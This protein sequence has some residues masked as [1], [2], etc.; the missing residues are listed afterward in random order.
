MNPIKV[1]IKMSLLMF[2]FFLIACTGSVKDPFISLGDSTNGSLLTSP[3][4]SPTPTG[5][6]GQGGNGTGGDCY[7]IPT[8]G[9]FCD[10]DGG[11]FGNDQG[12]I[13]VNLLNFNNGESIRGG[14]RYFIRYRA[15]LT[16]E[17]FKSVYSKIEVKR[18]SDPDTA[19]KLVADK[20]T[21]NDKQIVEAEWKVCPHLELESCERNASGELVPVNGSNFQIRITS[22]RLANQSGSAVSSG[23]FTI[24]SEAPLLATAEAANPT[25]GLFSSSSQPA[26]PNGFVNL[27]LRAASDN[28]SAIKSLCLK[29][30]LTVPD[31]SDGCWAPISTFSFQA[32]DVDGRK[33]ISITSLPLFLGFGSATINY[34]L[35]L[36]DYSGN[37]SQ[38]T[39]TT[40]NEEVIV[41]VIGKDKLSIT[42]AKVEHAGRD[43]LYTPV[44]TGY[45]GGIAFKTEMTTAPFSQNIDK[46]S[47]ADPGSLVVTSSGIAYIKSPFGAGG[48]TPGILKFNLY[49]G[50]QS[51]L[52]PRGNHTV[53]KLDGTAK[54]NDPLRIALDDNENLWV[55]DRDF[56]DKVVI[57]KI[58]GLS[59]NSPT[60][61]DVIGGGNKS[62]IADMKA[63]DLQITYSENLRWFGTFVALPDGLLVFSSEN[64]IRPLKATAPNP[65]FNLRVYRPERPIENRIETLTFKTQD[66]KDVE[67]LSPDTGAE[68]KTMEVYGALSVAFDW[69]RRD[70]GKIYG[71][72]CA[73]KDLGG[74]Q[75]TCSEIANFVY[76]H[77]GVFTSFLS[78]PGPW[79]W[80]NEFFMLSKTQ[81]LFSINS[82]RGRVSKL[83]GALIGSNW[84]DLFTAD[85]AGA[86]YCANGTVAGQCSVRLRDFHIHASGR[87]Y[88]ID[89]QRLR[90]IDDD[91]SVQSILSFQ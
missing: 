43:A 32:T 48:S 76:E 91:G 27:E 39:E 2:S 78:T 75:R 86:N 79:M 73:P 36:M 9:R 26:T 60:M 84:V 28:L 25:K 77:N 82:Y 40:E 57:S 88:F 4:P 37:I 12:V 61:T 58:T 51:V 50:V 20:I 15:N 10:G 64:P 17:K 59:T 3:T 49:T 71:R 42:K 52:L 11:I 89:D 34:F 63:S 56:D 87:I 13:T 29:S 31:H 8:I 65:S 81:D 19:W 45:S 74:G 44:Q 21:S 7:E 24:D 23:V 35:W 16:Y 72:A 67:I 66:L 62:D 14:G 30:N 38:L 68:L 46:S 47:M 33:Q 18:Q 83:R 85:G 1:A 90:F 80:G 5:T 54:V 55:M 41:G 22:N 53:G 70:V 69:E 6:P